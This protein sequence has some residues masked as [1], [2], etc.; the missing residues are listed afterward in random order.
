MDGQTWSPATHNCYKAILSL[1]YRL[2]IE[3]NKAKTNPGRLLKRRVESNVRLRWL[4]P[5]E[6][7]K[8]RS[9][10][11]RGFRWHLSEF[12]VALNTGM[13]PSEMF[14]LRWPDVDL[15]RRQITLLKNENREATAHPNQLGLFAGVRGVEG[16]AY[17]EGIHSSEPERGAVDRS[18]VV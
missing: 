16:S 1:I 11:E 10:I 4:L 17:P 12:E 6:E 2:A 18:S 15:N 9:A 8:L 7:I 13:R 3:S 5:D 14:G